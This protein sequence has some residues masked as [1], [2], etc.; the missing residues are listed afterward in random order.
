[1]S[2][3]KSKVEEANHSSK[4]LYNKKCNVKMN[5]LMEEAEQQKVSKEYHIL[6]FNC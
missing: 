2:K 6:D 4:I 3:Y 1:V 5:V